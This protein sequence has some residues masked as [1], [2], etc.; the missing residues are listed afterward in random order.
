VPNG[1]IAKGEALVT[2]GAGG[3]TIKCAACH[4]QTLQGLTGM[5]PIAGRQ[6]TYMVRQLFDYQDG[7]RSGPSA[8]LM[9]SL[10]E[11]LTVDDMLAIAAYTAS[12]EP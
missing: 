6:A 2:T 3:S 10:V 5:P 1:S 4:G 11:K 9:Q 8:T 12:L 7:T